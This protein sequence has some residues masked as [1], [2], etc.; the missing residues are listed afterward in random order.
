VLAIPPCSFTPGGFAAP[1][2]EVIAED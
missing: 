2:G 1:M